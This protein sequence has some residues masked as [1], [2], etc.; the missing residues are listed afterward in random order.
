MKTRFGSK[1]SYMCAAL[2]LA[3]WGVAEFAGAQSGPA[4]LVPT[5]L[6]WKAAQSYV[7]TIAKDLPD[8]YAGA[9]VASEPTLCFDL[10]GNVS[11][12]LFDILRDSAR[13]GYVVAGADP[14]GPPVYTHSSGISPLEKRDVAYRALGK[15]S[16]DL[17]ADLAKGRGR[18]LFLG[19][20][21]LYLRAPEIES[22]TTRA[23]YIRLMDY[24]PVGAEGMKKLQ[25]LRAENLSRWKKAGTFK[26]SWTSIAQYGAKKSMVSAAQPRQGETLAML[27][28]SDNNLVPLAKNAIASLPGTMDGP[29]D[30]FPPRDKAGNFLNVLERGKEYIITYNY[31]QNAKR[32]TIALYHI[33]PGGT[34][35]F[36]R[37]IVEGLK[38]DLSGRYL[39]KITSD[40]EPYHECVLGIWDTDR[41]TISYVRTQPFYIS[42]SRTLSVDPYLFYRAE[43]ASAAAMCLTYF[44]K[45]GFPDLNYPSRD[46][47]WEPTSAETRFTHAPK[48]LVDILAKNM[49][50][51]SIA[52]FSNRGGVSLENQ[53]QGVRSTV[54]E[55]GYGYW[56]DN[57]GGIVQRQAPV[58]PTNDP[59]ANI[60]T[61]IIDNRRPAILGWP[62]NPVDY[63]YA[64]EW[65]N[66]TEW[67]QPSLY[68]SATCLWGFAFHT[69]TNDPA[70]R[71]FYIYHPFYNRDTVTFAY[72]SQSG[73]EGSTI[74]DYHEM[75]PPD[76]VVK[77]PNSVETYL[78]P[79]QKIKIKWGSWASQTGHSKVKIELYRKSALI[80]T[81]ASGVSNS[82]SFDWTVPANLAPASDYRIKITSTS[83]S[84]VYDYSDK[85][86]S[87][88]SGR[89]VLAPATSGVIWRKGQSYE[90][91]W[92]GF[93]GANV[94]IDLYRNGVYARTIVSSTPNDGSHIWT[95]PETVPSAGGFSIRVMEAS[96][97]TQFANS[98][99][100]FFIQSW[101]KVLAPNL[102]RTYRMG[103]A[104]DITWSGFTGTTVSIA[105][106]VGTDH[107]TTVT[108]STPNDGSY[109]WVIPLTYPSGG[110]Y[111]VKIT[112][113]GTGA[114]ADYDFS[115]QPFV[116]YIPE[117]SVD[118]SPLQG[119]IDTSTDVDFYRFMLPSPAIVSLSTSASILSDTVM[120]L[121]GSSVTAGPS[122]TGDGLQNQR[123]LLSAKVTAAVPGVNEGIYNNQ[124]EVDDDDGPQQMSRI[125]RPLFQVGQYYFVKVR[126]YTTD[127][128]GA[129]YV[130]LTTMSAPQIFINSFPWQSS[131][132]TP[133]DVD[134]TTFSITS[135][136]F[137]SIE[138]FVE[139]LPAAKMT[140]YDSRGQ[141][142]VSLRSSAGNA[143]IYRF[144]PTGMYYLKTESGIEDGIG[145]FRIVL[146][147]Q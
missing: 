76:M 23:E 105:L 96:N 121:Y 130:K 143:R 101:P 21:G 11:A 106:F 71:I 145:S 28:Q 93:L 84:R 91:R 124:I 64:A 22:R 114:V 133:G 68:G 10:E 142:L 129:Y 17:R 83:S 125:D 113:R 52:S 32:V 79:G 95:V 75:V 89:V 4:K 43:A 112:S 146:S 5:D 53:I 7:D 65:P 141:Q 54:Y 66:A 110:G 18:I 41:P 144:M 128:R 73:P 47:G 92:R 88:V 57:F 3:L 119:S 48:E 90:I 19:G 126:P 77:F 14:D 63:T 87:I 38:P 49:G 134:W 116:I 80:S 60:L 13:A 86:F 85:Y 50:I 30:V 135:A 61:R 6:A 56:N 98:P 138:A 9:Q 115:D 94:R 103:A 2:I 118:G 31:P 46:F 108:A 81:I 29:I 78:A 100:T 97:T 34:R 24:E 69:N 140:L 136:G 40:Y 74:I 104:Y 45:R 35:V 33:S 127:L 15:S 39:W 82:G 109:R 70:S 59:Q 111:K 131:I 44:G 55:H 51:E 102:N 20:L 107:F 67:E 58:T 12:Y 122:R 120:H 36:I 132:P 62:G 139:T 37:T 117:L 1:I 8:A 123:D 147:R 72:E 137:I 26:A 99:G 16:A 42:A 25:S 27:R